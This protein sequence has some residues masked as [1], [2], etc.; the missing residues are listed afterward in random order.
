METPDFPKS[1]RIALTIAADEMGVRVADILGPS[2]ARNIVQGRRRAI[3]H[4]RRMNLSYSQIARY[5]GLNHT[6][7]IYHVRIDKGEAAR[8]PR[9]FTIPC[10]D[11]S[12]EWAI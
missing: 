1:I 4:L 8:G 5:L 10:P 11:L 2:S 3:R 6:T 9:N 7:V 12:G